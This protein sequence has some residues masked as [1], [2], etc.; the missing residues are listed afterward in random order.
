[1]PE[2]WYPEV[3]EKL[4]QVLRPQDIIK[5]SQSL[6]IYQKMEAAVALEGRNLVPKL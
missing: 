2:N 5:N 4:P 6:E 1:L 3:P